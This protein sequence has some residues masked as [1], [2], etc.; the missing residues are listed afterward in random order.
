MLVALLLV[1]ISLAVLVAGAEVLI[2]GSVGLARRMGVSNLFIGLTIVGFGTSAPELSASITATLADS[3]GIAVGNAVG[4]NIC[5][6]ALIVGL[7]A[8]IRPIP[9]VFGAVRKELIVAILVGAAPFLALAT[10]GVLTRWLAGMMLAALVAYIWLGWIAARRQ[11]AVE[12]A[13]REALGELAVTSHT[14]A[15]RSVLLVLAGLALLVGGA[16]VLVENAVILAK[17]MG[18][19]EVVIGLTVV[20]IGTSMP[21][22]LTSLV[23]AV[24]KQSDI[25]VGNIIGSNI[26]NLL[27][28][29]PAAALVAPLAIQTSVFLVDLPVALLLV[30]VLVPMCKSGSRISRGEGAVLLGAFVAYTVFQYAWAPALFGG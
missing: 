27:G 26:F 4:S 29:L 7:S 20:A 11:T 6:V 18:V 30:V 16:R 1:G 24:R 28:I 12:T 13:A 25:A 10:G 22:L 2:R 9:V 14:P 21:E 3:G 19:S 8:L 5:N 23:A 17:E 15:W